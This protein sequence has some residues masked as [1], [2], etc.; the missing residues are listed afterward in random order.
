VIAVAVMDA[1]LGVAAVLFALAGAALLFDVNG[2]AQHAARN[3]AQA[4]SRASRHDE[5]E[6]M[7]TTPGAAKLL[8]GCVMVGAL[9]VVALVLTGNVST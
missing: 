2:F 6:F 1:V 9:G 3:G 8:G 4:R 7:P 5:M